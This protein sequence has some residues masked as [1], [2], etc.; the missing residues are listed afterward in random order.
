LVYL[1]SI[2]VYVTELNEGDDNYR[3]KVCRWE[4]EIHYT[5]IA[6]QS[7]YSAVAIMS[8]ANGDVSPL[9]AFD[10]WGKKADA[11]NINLATPFV[12]LN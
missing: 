9:R 2:H 5:R 4:R 6:G 1:F 3:L 8:E 7:L 11:P 10:Q 12:E